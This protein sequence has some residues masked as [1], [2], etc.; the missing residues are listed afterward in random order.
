MA[1]RSV[2]LDR[3]VLASLTAFL[4]RRPAV[5]AWAGTTDGW[6]IG[7]AGAMLLGDGHTWQSFPW[8][9]VATGGWDSAAS[10]LSWQDADGVQHQA[11]L[12]GG[13]R[14]AELFN[15]RVSA[16]IVVS[17]PV[18]L[19][20]GQQVTLALRRN[21]KPGADQTGWQVVPGAGVD[22]QHPATQ[23]R[24]DQELAAAQADFGLT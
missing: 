9:Q 8:H 10:R 11:V 23:A 4:G 3:T 12:E 1:R 22:L 16:S 2:R 6:V 15:E 21:L 24:I 20:P 7:L 17:R 19:A 13:G 18:D 14:F 5:L